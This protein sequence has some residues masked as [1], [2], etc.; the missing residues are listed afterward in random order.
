MNRKEMIELTDSALKKI[1]PPEHRFKCIKD[2]DQKASHEELFKR[3]Y[4]LNGKITERAMELGIADKDLSISDYGWFEFPQFD[5]TEELTDSQKI[6][7]I[8]V[9]ECKPIHKW[10]AG[11]SVINRGNAYG[12][13]CYIFGTA[14]STREQAIKQGAEKIRE[15]MQKNM[16][17]KFSKALHELSSLLSSLESEPEQLEF[18]F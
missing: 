18:E 1:Y 2:E 6:W 12:K 11:H 14:Y 10:F 9:G 4:E 5:N 15:Y 7:K 13:P 3:H 16:T 8:T 17:D